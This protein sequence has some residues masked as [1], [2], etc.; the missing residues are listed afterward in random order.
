VSEGLTV[1]EPDLEALLSQCVWSYREAHDRGDIG[2]QEQQAGELGTI[3]ARLLGRYLEGSSEWNRAHWI[4]DLTSRSIVVLSA[5]SIEV[6]GLIV[7]GERRLS[8]QWVEPFLAKVSAAANDEGTVT[9][10]L[11]FGSVGDGLGRFPYGSRGARSEPADARDWL[12]TFRKEATS[13]PTR[14]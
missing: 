1:N 9:Y 14:E 3:L 6:R 12:F 7:W 13:P 5:T 10:V 4:D 8:N 11:A 2:G